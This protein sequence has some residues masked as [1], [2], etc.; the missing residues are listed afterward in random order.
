MTSP[1]NATGSRV[2]ERAMRRTGQ[3]Y[4]ACGQPK[5]SNSRLCTDCK[6]TNMRKYHRETPAAKARNRRNQQALYARRKAARLAA[7]AAKA[8]E[9]PNTAPTTPEGTP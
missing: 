5:K 8:T 7:K 2:A 4:C 6:V 9:A 3:T 1:T